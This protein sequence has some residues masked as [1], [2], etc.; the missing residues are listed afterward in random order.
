MDDDDLACAEE[1]LRYRERA[2]GLNGAPAR[3]AD[4]V[5]V[6]LLQAQDLSRVWSVLASV[7]ISQAS[8]VLVAGF[9]AITYL[10]S[11]PCKP[12]RLPFCIRVRGQ[13]IV[14]VA[15]CPCG[16]WLLLTGPG[17]GGGAPW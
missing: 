10:A 3:V 9:V 4:D 8:P 5:G 17:G 12:R 15:G 2:D 14:H 7:P 1:L 13:E 16:C 6:A 11:R